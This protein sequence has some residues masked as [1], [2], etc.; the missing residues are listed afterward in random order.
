[1]LYCFHISQQLKT[2]NVLRIEVIYQKLDCLHV[3]WQ[4]IHFIERL[5]AHSLGF[6]TTEMKS[7]WKR[8]LQ[9][10][11]QPLA[12]NPSLHSTLTVIK[13]DCAG[14]LFAVYKVIA[15]FG[16]EGAA[17]GQH[18]ESILPEGAFVVPAHV[19]IVHHHVSLLQAHDCG[20]TG[21]WVSIIDRH[22]T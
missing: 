13:V 6:S 10:R 17:S 1:M 8:L 18:G 19:L 14:V 3:C 2:H 16:S 12:A 22:I 15:D 21:H 9:V 7:E 11:P 4:L 5:L 20:N